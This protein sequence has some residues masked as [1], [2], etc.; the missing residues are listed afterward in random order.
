MGS[1]QAC[2]QIW[3][4]GS[5]I[6]QGVTYYSFLLLFWHDLCKNNG[7]D[8]HSIFYVCVMLHKPGNDAEPFTVLI[9]H[10]EMSRKPHQTPWT[11]R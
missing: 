4:S 2:A 9:V 5:L 10:R 6:W 7:V 11:Y 1:H 8:A 3:G